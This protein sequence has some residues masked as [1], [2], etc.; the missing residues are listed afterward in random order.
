MTARCPARPP[1]SKREK[2]MVE[3]GNGMAMADHDVHA[4]EGVGEAN[5]RSVSPSMAMPWR[6]FQRWCGS[7]RLFQRARAHPAAMPWRA[8]DDGH[9]RHHQEHRTGD[10]P[11]GG[12]DDPAGGGPGR[13]RLSQCVRER[14][15][16]CLSF[17]TGGGGRHD[18]ATRRRRDQPGT[19]KRRSD[20]GVPGFAERRCDDHLA[21]TGTATGTKGRTSSPA[22]PHLASLTPI[23]ARSPAPCNPP[24]G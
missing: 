18:D 13:D 1:S 5:P 16:R 9:A 21:G 20:P 11:R 6:V 19:G 14:Q 7:S 15:S 23:T 22:H 24:P 17:Q 3:P 8:R 10:S 2:C 4:T 12:A